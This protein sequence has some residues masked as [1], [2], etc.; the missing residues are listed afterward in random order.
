MNHLPHLLPTRTWLSPNPK[1]GTNPPLPLPI[2]TKS[3]L[4]AP[5]YQVQAPEINEGPSVPYWAWAPLIRETTS[6]AIETETFAFQSCV[7]SCQ[8]SQVQPSN[9]HIIVQ[10]ERRKDRNPEQKQ[11]PPLYYSPTKAPLTGAHRQ[12]S[13][14]ISQPATGAAG[15][16]EGP[17]WGK[18][19]LWRGM[20]VQ[21]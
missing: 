11:A 7:D 20:N 10:R 15:K 6:T 5:V 9:K 4:L 13:Q 18:G 8:G 14:Q 16:A 3:Q 21:V 19:D 2:S 12:R 1:T 17:S